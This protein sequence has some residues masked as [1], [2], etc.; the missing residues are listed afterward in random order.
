VL[1]FFSVWF[2]AQLNADKSSPANRV[3]AKQTANG[4]A[5][6]K[7]LAVFDFSAGNR[8]RAAFANC[9][10]PA[11]GALQVA[12]RRHYPPAVFA[13]NDR[14]AGGQKI[15]EAAQHQLNRTVRR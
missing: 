12:S 3:P 15:F 9:N 11:S 14:F 1:I 10:L 4:S 2:A 7:D 5:K 8:T 6:I 13:K